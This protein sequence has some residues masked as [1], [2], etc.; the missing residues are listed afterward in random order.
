MTWALVRLFHRPPDG[1][2]AGDALAGGLYWAGATLLGWFLWFIVC[3]GLWFD[4]PGDTDLGREPQ[5]RCTTE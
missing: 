4:H 1:G 2:W 5:D 3:I